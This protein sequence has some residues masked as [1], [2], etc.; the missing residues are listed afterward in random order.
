MLRESGI[1]TFSQLAAP[2]VE[3]LQEVLAAAGLGADP[4]S[5]PEQASLAEAEDWEAFQKLKDELAAG[6]HT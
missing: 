6:R 4:S 3:H 2:P 1:T 5:W